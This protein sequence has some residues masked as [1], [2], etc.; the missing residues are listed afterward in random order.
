MENPASRH[1]SFIYPV[2]LLVVGFSLLAY[3]LEW[4]D[5]SPWR[6]LMT[7]WP[8]FI[9][10]AGLDLLLRRTST[11]ISLSAAL[12]FAVLL[13]L[14]MNAGGIKRHASARAEGTRVQPVEVPLG[15]ATSAYVEL[16][17]DS[18]DIEL[19]AAAP[20][21]RRLVEGEA[22]LPLGS[23]LV[24][25]QDTT[26]PEGK[27]RIESG[28]KHRHGAHVSWFGDDRVGDHRWT[29]GL[30]RTVPMDVDI[31]VNAGTFN[32]DFSELNIASVKAEINAGTGEL[33]LSK[34]VAEGSADLSVQ[35]GTLKITVPVECAAR[36]R[37]EGGLNTLHGDRDR[38]TKTADGYETSGDG[39]GPCR[40]EISVHGNLSSLSLQ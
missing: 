40:W 22:R 27:V 20:G 10:A 37:T 3:N 35:V 29:L 19:S 34:D 13:I 9:V 30:A 8:L 14:L 38:Y 17:M 12:L 23:R 11:W 15:Q 36:V 24:V 7:L 6:A 21:G 2:L 18:G 32:L 33:Q 39:K 28:L 16:H 1:R 5:W 4:I 31:Q 25:D 26:G